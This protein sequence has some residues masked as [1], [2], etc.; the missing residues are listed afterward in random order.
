M[1]Y[2]TIT[3]PVA[4]A[5]GTWT[6][7]GTFQDRAGALWRTRQ[8]AEGQG[9]YSSVLYECV[10]GEHRPRA[11]VSRTVPAPG[12]RRNPTVQVG[13]DAYLQSVTA[14]RDAAPSEDGERD[15]DGTPLLTAKELGEAYFRAG[16]G[17]TEAYS[18]ARQFVRYW[19]RKKSRCPGRP[20]STRCPGS[21]ALRGKKFLRPGAGAGRVRLWRF[22]A[23]DAERILRGEESE[24][25]GVGGQGAYKDLVR[26]SPL[27]AERW[28]TGQ[29]ADGPRRPDPILLAAGQRKPPIPLPKLRAAKKKL[30]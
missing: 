6:E 8:W 24:C 21:R 26:V 14:R 13:S 28:L 15:G 27:D 3:H 12:P 20:A 22:R 25:P 5:G 2:P 29:L 4:V 16:Q 9:Y 23:D 10:E 30:E 11:G 17:E 18:G 1:P 7:E 19:H